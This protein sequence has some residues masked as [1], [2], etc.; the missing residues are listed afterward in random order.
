MTAEVKVLYYADDIAVFCK[1]R[2]SISEAVSVAD[3]YCK[4]SGSALNWDKSA[5]FWHGTW[6]EK[7]EFFE[8]VKWSS[9][10]TKYLGVPLQK[11]N[12]P[13]EY[14]NDE[15]E[16]LREKANKWG[17]K[18]L[19][20]FA[21]STVCNLFLAAKIWYVLQ[22]LC[23]NRSN[24]QKI[25]RVFATFVWASTWERTSRTNLFRSVKAGGLGLAH[26]FLRQIVSRFMFLRDQSHPF[27]RTMLQV[28]LCCY[29]PEFVVST[30]CAGRSGIHGY[31]H[32]AVSAFNI[33]KVRFSLQYLGGVTKRQLYKDLIDIMLPV[34]MYRA[35]YEKGQGKDVLKRVKRMVVRP[36]AN[37]FFF[38]LH[39]GTLPVKPWLQER[40]LFVPW[41]VNCLLCRKPESVD[42]I[43]LDCLDATFHWDIL[44]RTL[45][46]DLP[47]TPH[48]IRF[49]P[50]HSDSGIP[51]DM[52][53]LLSMHAI[54]KSCMAFRHVDANARSVREYFIESIAYIRD[55]Y[56]AREEQPEWLP[57][58]NELVAK[59]LLNNLCQTK[60]DWRF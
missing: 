51:Y 36:S 47:L 3:K 10:P 29:L 53:M 39:T 52:F 48:G 23:M 43:F 38:Q 26:L 41:S 17:G 34:P 30:C 25:H 16:K 20:I 1:D 57:V 2:G 55:A 7:P 6:D 19:S 37:T 4:W 32:E 49:L 44:Q 21:R 13:S 50:V 12:D 45:K 28:R 35:M 27:L 31:L 56:N 58:L 33:L 22:V 46:K 5:I 54:W 40:G 9:V 59:A 14:W 42:H 18:N 8:K 11:Y 24:V 15:T 60:C